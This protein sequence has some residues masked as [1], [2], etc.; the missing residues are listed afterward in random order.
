MIFD[1]PKNMFQHMTK[2]DTKI[3]DSFF[4][5][6][7]IDKQI[8]KAIDEEFLNLI[9][10]EENNMGMYRKK[11]VIVEA[12]QWTGENKEEII[13]FVDGNGFFDHN[14]L[15]I[16]TLEGKLISK[17][18]D[19]IIKGIDGEFYPCKEKI[20]NETYERAHGYEMDITDDFLSHDYNMD[21]K[22][23]RSR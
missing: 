5:I 22:P 19:Y 17:P 14:D 4:I 20:F 15:V 7:S 13:G 8:A 12:I 23:F 16:K 18:G 10:R 21:T 11:P 3:D 2:V 9:E 6:D 1:L